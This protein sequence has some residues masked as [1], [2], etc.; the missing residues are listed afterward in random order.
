MGKVLLAFHKWFFNFCKGS[1]FVL[2]K[3]FT[4]SEKIYVASR[5]TFFIVQTLGSKLF[6]ICEEVSLLLGESC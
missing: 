4:S 5:K 1:C 6:S 2:I 3:S